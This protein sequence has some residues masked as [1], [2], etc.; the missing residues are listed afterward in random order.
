MRS[1]RCCRRQSAGAGGRADAVPGVHDGAG[2]RRSAPATSPA[3]PR[4]SSP[5]GRARCSGSG[6]TASSRRPSSSAKPCSAFGSAQ[7]TATRSASGPMYYLRDG[8]KSPALAWIYALVAGVAALTTTPFT[9]PNSIALARATACS[10]CRP[11]V[12]GVVVAVLTWAGHHRRHQVDRPRRREARAAQGRALSRRRAGRHRLVR[13]PAAGRPVAR[14]ARGVHDA[15]R[16]TGIRRV[17]GDA[18][19]RRAR[20]LRQRGRLRHG[21]RRLRHGPS[22]QPHAA[23]PERRDGGVHRL[24]RHVDHQRDDDSRERRGRAVDRGHAGGAAVTSTAAVAAAFDAADADRSGGW[25]VAFCAFLF[26]YTTLIGWA[27]LRRA[28]PRVHLRPPRRRC[29]IAGSTAC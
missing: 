14:R 27:L 4:P 15:S 11:W 29:R 22:D 21:G 9:Q 1:A 26:G 2:A 5:A 23:G 24:V 28:V 6:S 12:A 20:H 25:V 8:L 10:A 17:R 16:A 18:L 3:S 19:R 13:G 7:A